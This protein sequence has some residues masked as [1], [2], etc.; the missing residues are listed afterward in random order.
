MHIENLDK[1]LLLVM[2]HC[3][4][5]PFKTVNSKVVQWRQSWHSHNMFILVQNSVNVF[6][7]QRWFIYTNL[8]LHVEKSFECMRK[9]IGNNIL[10]QLNFIIYFR[11]QIIQEKRFSLFLQCPSVSFFFFFFNV[12]L[13]YNSK[14]GFRA[15]RYHGLSPKLEDWIRPSL[16][17]YKQFHVW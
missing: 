5:I 9:S 3:V 4:S 6:C 2:H 12:R 8:P 7:F 15:V 14:H 10:K 13:S 16:D 17:M 11:T 1:K